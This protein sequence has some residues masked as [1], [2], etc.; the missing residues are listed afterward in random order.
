MSKQNSNKPW[1]KPP[2][3]MN[4]GASVIIIGGGIAGLCVYLHLK[5]AGFKVT[6]IDKN[7]Y[8]LSE[9]SGNPAAVLEP[10]VSAAQSRQSNYYLAAYQYALEFYSSLSGDVLL[11]ALV[12]RIPKDE[13]EKESF[14]Q[15]AESYNSDI[16]YLQ[17]NDL[18]LPSGGYVVPSTLRALIDD[19]FLGGHIITAISQETDKTWSVFDQHGDKIT[20]ADGVVLANAFDLENFD[21]ASGLTLDQV[22]GQL[23]YV[24]PEFEER[25]ILFSKGYVTPV[26]ETEFGKAHICGATFERQI[27]PVLS[28]KAHNENIAKSPYPFSDPKIIGGRRAIRAMSPDHFPLCGPA[29]NRSQYLIDYDGL[30]HGPRHKN[31][32]D[33]TYHHNL[34]ILAGV[35]ARGFVHAP[36]LA[37]HLTTLITK[38]K[39]LFDDEIY[40]ALHPARFFIR[41]LSKK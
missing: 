20:N 39:S 21:Q 31:F 8:P 36:I 11:P 40:R 17:D 33:A 24:A 9:A 6:I 37:K 18:I 1:F 15:I 13:D 12:K 16:L 2:S 27:N 28:A 22:E 30:W 14:P 5:S 41:Q 29:H 25:H 34:Y 32:P 3:P 35:G 26:V 23:S 38:G 10:F 19:G 7:D 4:E